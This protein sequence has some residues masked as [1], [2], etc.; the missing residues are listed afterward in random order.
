PYDLVAETARLGRLP[1]VNFSAG[2]IATP[3]DAALMMQLGCDGNFVG[4]GIFKSE[5]PVRMARAIVAATTYFDKPEV[6]LDVSR[7]LGSAMKGIEIAT[8]PRE[9]LLAS[10]GW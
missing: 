9:E 6:V 7:G 8:I 4:S 1:V 2:G 5:D 10:R 3:A